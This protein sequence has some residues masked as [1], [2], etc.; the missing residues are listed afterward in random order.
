MEGVRDAKDYG[1][2]CMQKYP[3]T[4]NGIGRQPASEDCLT[5]NVW[6]QGPSGKRP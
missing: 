2:V 3:S 4:D 5:L 1:N 6:T